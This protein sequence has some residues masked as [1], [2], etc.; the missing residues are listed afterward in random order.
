MAGY[1]AEQHPRGL[2]IEQCKL[3]QMH[4]KKIVGFDWV[5][6]DLIRDCR[7]PGQNCR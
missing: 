6:L 4:F 7:T 1:F 3:K 2:L 5:T